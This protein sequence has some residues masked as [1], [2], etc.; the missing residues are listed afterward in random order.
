MNLHRILPCAAL[1]LTAP[2]LAQISVEGFETGN[3]DGWEVWFS[4]YNTVQTGGGNPNS[5]LEL[6]NFTQGSSS[7][8]FVEIT[9][10]GANG[11]TSF[12]HS[13]NWRTAGV[14]EVSID[15]DIDQGI[16][17]GDLELILTSDLGTPLDPTDDC[18]ISLRQVGA[19]ASL[20]GWQTYVF[21]VPSAQTSAPS[22]WDIAAT[23]NCFGSI[24]ALWNTVMQDVDSLQVIYDGNPP[25]FC[26]F[27]Q[28][29]IGVDNITV[30]VGTPQTI[31]TNYCMANPNTTGALAGMSATGSAVASVNHLEL[32]CAGMPAASFGFFL[33]SRATGFVAMPAGSSG[34]LCLSGAIG[35]F[36]GPGQIQNSGTAGEIALALDLTRQPTPTGLVAV[37]AGETWHFTAWFRDAG[38]TGPT[39]NF[40]D[41]LTVMFL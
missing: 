31:G 28:W 30:S 14:N 33:T 39:S 8:H 5:Y 23:S 35:R 6:D 38:A 11:A 18:S 10:G 27:T 3:V 13:G 32:N 7:C 19:G 26:N 40:A 1:A 9:P 17:G 20:A 36:V 37:N 22:G 21:D 41:G 24:D 25:A 2:A 12:V 4:V 15:L 29:L 16:Y 34:N